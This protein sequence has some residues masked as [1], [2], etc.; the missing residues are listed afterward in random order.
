MWLPTVR[1]LMTSICAIAVRPWP[2][3]S[4]ASTSSSLGVRRRWATSVRSA[5]SVS[6]VLRATSLRARDEHARV[7]GLDE[8]VVRPEQ[9]PGGSIVIVRLLARDEDDGQFLAQLLAQAPPRG[10]LA[11]RIALVTGGASGIG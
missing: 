8:V 3:A 4:S 5:A 9:E 2:S 10:E 1:G 7:E 6:T 11:G